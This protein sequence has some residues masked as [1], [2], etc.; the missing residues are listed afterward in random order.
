MV[1]KFQLFSPAANDKK[2]TP[3]KQMTYEMILL[4]GN[5][6][7]Y[8][9]YGVKHIHKNYFWSIGLRDTTLLFVKIYEGPDF[10]GSILGTAQLYITVPNFAKQLSTID[11]T[12]A[13]NIREKTYWLAKFGGF[14]IKTLWDV[15]GPG[16]PAHSLNGEIITP[17]Q[18]RPLKLRGCVPVVYDVETEDKVVCPVKILN[19]GCRC[20]N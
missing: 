14:F 3:S 6:A 18:K 17:R 4:D 8:S 19:Q 15:Y 20:C 5:S 11:I 13:Q 9:F 16:V 2:D 7:T 10:S 12:H 1:G